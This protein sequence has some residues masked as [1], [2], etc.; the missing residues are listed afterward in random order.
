MVWRWWFFVYSFFSTCLPF[1]ARDRHG[2]YNRKFISEIGFHFHSNK[3]NVDI[4]CWYYVSG[5]C[6]KATKT[7]DTEKKWTTKIKCLLCDF[8]PSLCC[9]CFFFLHSRSYGFV[10]VRFSTCFSFL[11]SRF[12]ILYA[13]NI[14]LT[15]DYAQKWKWF[16]RS[17]SR[18]W[19]ISRKG[20]Q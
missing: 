14:A 1:N 8:S 3:R 4:S 19:E 9:F 20:S 10:G 11:L 2:N 16:H 15:D 5:S 6:C 17:S 13:A 7:H 18:E 12:C